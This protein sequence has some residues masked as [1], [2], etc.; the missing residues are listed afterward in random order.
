MNLRRSRRD[1]YLGVV[2]PEDFDPK[3]SERTVPV[4]R[5]ACSGANG[6]DGLVESWGA[7]PNDDLTA[8]IS[9][10]LWQSAFLEQVWSC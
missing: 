4:K 6:S 8:S 2:C 1:E 5:N 7:P 3:Q 10:L 9:L